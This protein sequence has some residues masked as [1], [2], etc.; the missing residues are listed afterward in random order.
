[1][2]VMDKFHG[3]LPNRLRNRLSNKNT[4]LVIIPSGMTG[5]LE[6]LDVSFNKPFRHLLCK[7]C[8]AWLDKDNHILTPSGK[9]KRA[10][11]SIIVEWISKAWKEVPVN[12]IPKSFLLYLMQ[13]MERKMTLFGTT[14]NKVARVHHLQKMKC[15]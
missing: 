2:L 3:H 5:Q 12:I 7:H 13:K 8:N 15:D 9:I 1:M 4:D 6:P 11:A 10:S 14:V